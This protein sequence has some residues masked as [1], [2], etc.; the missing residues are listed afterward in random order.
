LINVYAPAESLTKGAYVISEA[1][2]D[3]ID[4]IIASSGSEY[5][6]VLKGRRN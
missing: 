2:K 6:Y 4:V 3:K 5:H 1:G